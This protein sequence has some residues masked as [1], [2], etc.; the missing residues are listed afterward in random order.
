MQVLVDEVELDRMRH[1]ARER[2]MSL[3]EWVRQTLREACRREPL[4]NADR[5][6]AHVRAALAHEFP[7]PSIEQMLEEIARGYGTGEE[8]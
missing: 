5:K 1:V 8:G 3:A 2:H 6:L 7:A 4:R